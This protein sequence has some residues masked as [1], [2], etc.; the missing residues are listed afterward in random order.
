MGKFLKCFI[1]LAATFVLWAN[2]ASAAITK[3]VDG[4]VQ[5]TLRNIPVAGA[6]ITFSTTSVSQ[7]SYTATTNSAGYYAIG[8]LVWY[9][10]ENSN[11]VG[12]KITVTA[13]GYDS[14]STTS[15]S[16]VYFNGSS[17]YN[18][19]LKSTSAAEIKGAITDQAGKKLSGITVVLKSTDYGYGT[20]DYTVV[21]DANGN[22]DLTDVLAYVYSSG[23]V[24]KWVAYNLY[25][26]AAGYKNYTSSLLDFKTKRVLTQNATL[27]YAGQSYEGYVSEMIYSQDAVATGY[28]ERYIL[29]KNTGE[30]IGYIGIDRSNGYLVPFLQAAF[31]TRCKVVFTAGHI[32]KDAIYDVSYIELGDSS[33]ALSRIESKL[34]TVKE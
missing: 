21:T 4:Y 14:F 24:P 18:V 9:S 33:T 16:L 7:A 34:G 8:N 32:D 28:N 20:K 10:Y 5:D 13:A 19:S 30:A 12:Y 26:N 25:I 3:T 6:T 2:T 23:S 17:R 31:K 29:V 11:R 22:Y 1:V 15:G 27:T